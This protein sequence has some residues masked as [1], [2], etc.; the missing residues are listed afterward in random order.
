MAPATVVLTVERVQDAASRVGVT[1]TDEQAG[2]LVRYGQLLV[3][4]NNRFNLTSVADETGI[5]YRHFAD[6]LTAV[7]VCDR[8]C[9]AEG[10]SDHAIR[11]IDLG[12]GAGLPGIPLKIARPRLDITLVD[13]TGKKVDFCRQVIRELGLEGITALKGRAEEL[14]HQVGHRGRYDVAVAR[15]V[16]PL[17]LLAEYMLPLLRLGGT[18]L[19]MKG[20]NAAAEIELARR[21]IAAVGGQLDQVEE[22]T[23]PEVGHRRTLVV[24]KKVKPTP[25]AYP[26]PGGTPRLR[27]T[28][29]KT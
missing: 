25:D 29:Q 17:P 2:Q 9:G 13:G 3:D 6:S 8:L 26:R 27:R 24:L 10:P 19:A 5:L 4:A 22:F 15:A 16:A 18:A 7:R 11:L 23:L 28:V 20:A 12:T 14:A 21:A 1:L